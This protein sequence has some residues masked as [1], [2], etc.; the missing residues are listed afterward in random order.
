MQTETDS[1]QQKKLI[2]KAFVA[3]FILTI[4]WGYNWVVMKQAVQFASPFQFAAIRTFFGSIVL[5]ILIFLTKRPL[6]LKEFPTMLMLGLLQSC[7]FTGVLIWALVEGGAG[8]TAVL[9]YTMP[10][11]VM[12]FAWPMLGEKIQGWQWLV[13]LFALFGMVLIFDPLHIKADGFSMFLAVFS[14]VSWAISAI[15]SKKLHQRAPHLDLL[16]LT[17]WPMFLGSIPIVAIAFILPA[18]PMQWAP[19]FVFAV[20]FNVLL[21]GCLAWVLWLYALQRLQA[22]VASMA[23]MLAPVIGVIAA[24]IQL[25]EVPNTYELVGM[26]LIAL[27][28]VTISGIS[29]SKHTQID[30]AQGQE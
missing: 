23:S 28:L 26:V 14:G 22:G 5:F 9:T 1:K 29:I 13:V 16:N 6:A 15:V 27:S 3:L 25:N 20:L 18:P 30:P 17:A 4:I 11:W 21:S 12:L 7:G 2:V 10:F 19:T 8:K 24:W